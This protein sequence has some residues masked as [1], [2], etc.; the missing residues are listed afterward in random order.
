M[1]VL[2]LLGLPCA[3]RLLAMLSSLPPAHQVGNRVKSE[4]ACRASASSLSPRTYRLAR[5][6][7][8]KSA[9]STTEAPMGGQVQRE[10]GCDD[11]AWRGGTGSGPRLPAAPGRT[12]VE[13]ALADEQAGDVCAQ[14]VKVLCAMRG[15]SNEHKL[16]GGR[17]GV[18]YCA[19][20][21]RLPR[22]AQ[23]RRVLDHLQAVVVVP[24]RHAGHGPE[25]GEELVR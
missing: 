2:P 20:Q 13:P 22:L 15:L 10:Q 5:K 14:A 12:R 21:A 4:S 9:S 16:G 1:A 8:G 6:A 17:D 25:P 11:E 19:L 18:H 3:A 23:Q 7:S 24:G